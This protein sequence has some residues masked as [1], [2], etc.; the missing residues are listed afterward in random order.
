M[1]GGPEVGG[2]FKVRGGVS[3]L[4]GVKVRLRG[5]GGLWVH[6]CGHHDAHG[7]ACPDVGALHWGGGSQNLGGGGLKIWGGSQN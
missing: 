3:R 2:G 5:V 6:P 7:F 4:G 1:G